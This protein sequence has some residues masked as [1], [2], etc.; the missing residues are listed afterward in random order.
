VHPIT[1]EELLPA[2][3]FP[4]PPDAPAPI[5]TAPKAVFP[6]TGIHDIFLKPPAPPPPPLAPAPLPPPATTNVLTILVP[7]CVVTALG[8]LDVLVV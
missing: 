2:D 8:V 7:G 1:T 4:L 6:D 5:V 3:P